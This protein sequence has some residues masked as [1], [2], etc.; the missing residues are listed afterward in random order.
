MTPS[1]RRLAGFSLAGFA[2]VVLFGTVRSAPTPLKAWLAASPD[3]ERAM[4]SFHA[5]FD[6]LCWVGAA[7][8]AA[9]L[10]LLEAPRAPA[11]AAPACAVCY[12]AGSVAFSGGYA[13]K[14]VGLA[15][16]MPM[17]ATGVAV[18]LISIGGLLLIGAGASAARVLLG[19]RRQSEATRPGTGRK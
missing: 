7:A 16:G 9:A 14:A 10:H 12:M 13:L 1:V 18:G 8:L 5:H 15:A 2:L 17:L 19:A 6:A 11:W 4:A 3:A